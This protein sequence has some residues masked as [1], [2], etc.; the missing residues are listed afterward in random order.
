M[1]RGAQTE[2][3][4]TKHVRDEGLDTLRGAMIRGVLLTH[5]ALVASSGSDLLESP[6]ASVEQAIRPILMPVAFGLAGFTA[7]RTLGRLLVSS[8]KD[9]ARRLLWTWL[10]WSGVCVFLMVTVEQKYAAFTPGM[11][12]RSS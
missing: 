8:L 4:M 3:P 7:F 5:I 2:G 10:L 11:S 1:R 12:A 6:V 9:R